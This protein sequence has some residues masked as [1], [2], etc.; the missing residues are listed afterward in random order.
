MG[1]ITMHVNAPATPVVIHTAVPESET[2]QKIENVVLPFPPAPTK[3]SEVPASMRELAPIENNR[4]SGNKYFESIQ[5]YKYVVA[6]HELVN[7]TGCFAAVKGRHDRSKNEAE[8][9]FL[10]YLGN[11]LKLINGPNPDYKTFRERSQ[12]ISLLLREAAKSEFYQSNKT[13]NNRY[14]HLLQELC[15]AKFNGVY[16][17]DSF[18]DLVTK[19]AQSAGAEEPSYR[20]FER[21][22]CKQAYYWRAYS[23]CQ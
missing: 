14:C 12:K 17:H 4:E 22:K 11:A 1:N 7:K 15:D 8:R 20:S 9:T 18:T 5:G 13:E 21:H 23:R 19:A 16:P 6:D 2:R 3:V 10:T